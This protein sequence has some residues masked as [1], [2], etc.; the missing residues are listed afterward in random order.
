MP[1]SSDS[2]LTRL[3]RHFVWVCAG[4]DD[5]APPDGSPRSPTPCDGPSQNGA[6]VIEV[7]DAEA[8][9]RDTRDATVKEIEAWLTSADTT[10]LAVDAFVRDGRSGAA[11]VAQMA[12]ALD[13]LLAD[14]A[15]R[16]PN[17]GTHD[18]T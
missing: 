7:V 9:V 6:W 4:C 8:A 1:D 11:T 14:I 18:G 13:A 12:A 3:P 16:F 15:R 17:G 5:C 2:I 10:D